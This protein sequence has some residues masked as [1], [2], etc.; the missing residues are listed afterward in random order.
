MFS[1]ISVFIGKCKIELK[2]YSEISTYMS[3]ILKNLPS[4]VFY[5]IKAKLIKKDCILTLKEIYLSEIRNDLYSR[6][7]QY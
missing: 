4:Y 7:R 3:L 2:S 6:F 1:Y 5:F